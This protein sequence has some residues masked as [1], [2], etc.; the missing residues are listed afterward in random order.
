M[1][2]PKIFN[3]VKLNE[4]VGASHTEADRLLAAANVTV[5]RVG[6]TDVPASDAPLAAKISAIGALLATNNVSQDMADLVASN[7]SITRQL[8]AVSDRN[9]IL[10]SENASLT[11]QLAS[12]TTNLTTANGSV[13]TLTAS[14]GETANRLEASNRQVADHARTIK[15]GNEAVSRL[16]LEYNCLT[17]VGTDGRPLPA[18]A[19]ADQRLEAACAVPMDEKMASIRGAVNGALARTG[20]SVAAL[21]VPGVAGTQTG[22]GRRQMNATERC[23]EYVRTNG[24]QPANAG[25]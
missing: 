14:A 5:I 1:P 8:Q 4:I 23:M 22:Q 20:V 17:L 7:D 25:R 10:T 16:C 18:N 6:T 11:T 9:S 24:Q 13:T 2:L 21:P 12:A 19:S 15:S 3:I